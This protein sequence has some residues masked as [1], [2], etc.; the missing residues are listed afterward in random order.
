MK[1]R[2]DGELG[3]VVLNFDRDSLRFKIIQKKSASQKDNE[4][5]ENA[6]ADAVTMATEKMI[7]INEHQGVIYTKLDDA[8]DMN[9]DEYYS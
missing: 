7:G 1:N 8:V 2:F 5:E 4:E 3:A 9:V 6:E